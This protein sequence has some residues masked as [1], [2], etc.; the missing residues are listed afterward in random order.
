VRHDDGKFGNFRHSAWR[1]LVP[2]SS[3]ACANGA[4]LPETR[5][6]GKSAS[7]PEAIWGIGFFDT[8]KGALPFLGTRELINRASENVH[9]GNAGLYAQHASMSLSAGGP[10]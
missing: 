9:S 8:G 4:G 2:S 1:S 6:R 10:K 3:T 7:N 5:E